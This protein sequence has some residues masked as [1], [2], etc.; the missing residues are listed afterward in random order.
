M[1]LVENSFEIGRTAILRND[2]DEA[3]R[4]VTGIMLLPG[5]QIMYRLSFENIESWHY[6]FELFSYIEKVVD[7]DI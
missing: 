7:E 1:F 5:D 2:P 4:F 6:E 3:V